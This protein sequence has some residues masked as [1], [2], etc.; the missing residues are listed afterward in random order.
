M[1]KH[2]EMKGSRAKTKEIVQSYNISRDGIVGHGAPRDCSMG[3]LELLVG[4]RV[5]GKAGVH[6]SQHTFLRQQW[7]RSVLVLPRKPLLRRSGVL[8][9]SRGMVHVLRSWFAGTLN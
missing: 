6:L 7:S 2:W 9:S 5:L 1:L 8:E 4:S 3:L